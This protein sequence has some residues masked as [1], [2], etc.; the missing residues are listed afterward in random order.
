RSTAQVYNN[1]Q[2]ASH[3]LHEGLVPV[4][5]NDLS[6]RF[7][8]DVTLVAETQAQSGG[9]RK[10]DPR[11]GR[12]NLE[13]APPGARALPWLIPAPVSAPVAGLRRLCLPHSG[14]RA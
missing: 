7:Y 9:R 11:S 12:S 4:Q 5:N 6:A 10:N 3:P 13:W 14:G 1:L 2:N 8:R